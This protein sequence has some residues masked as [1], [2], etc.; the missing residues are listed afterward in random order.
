M[1]YRP[2]AFCSPGCS[3]CKRVPYR[4]IPGLGLSVACIRHQ[5]ADAP[6]R[7]SLVS[8]ALLLQGIQQFALLLHLEWSALVW[9]EREGLTRGSSR[10]Q[11]LRVIRRLGTIPAKVM[12][13]P[14]CTAGEV[15][16][17]ARTIKKYH[18]QAAANKVKIVH[19]CGFDSI[20]SDLGAH[21]VATHIQKQHHRSIGL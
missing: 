10:G 11:P 14:C 15:P 20:P 21:L 12:T 2:T 13:A 4:S 18:S 3:F 9:E 16:W 19:M 8:P 5:C 1:P 7:Y 17:V 6:T